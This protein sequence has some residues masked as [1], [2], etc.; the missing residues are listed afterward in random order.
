MHHQNIVPV[1]NCRD[2]SKNKSVCEIRND[3]IN[4]SIAF[5]FFDKIRVN[6]IV[7]KINLK[8]G[9]VFFNDIK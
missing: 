6:K 8:Y 4:K 2:E 7:K 5:L 9:I 1:K 3:F